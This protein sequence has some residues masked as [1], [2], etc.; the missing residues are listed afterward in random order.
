MQIKRLILLFLSFLFSISTLY[1][2]D[3]SEIV[4]AFEKKDVKKIETLLNSKVQF[5]QNQTDNIYSKTQATMVLDAFLKENN[6]QSAVLIHK[7]KKGISSF[8]IFNLITE[9]GNFRLYCLEKQVGDIFLIHQIRI[10]K[11]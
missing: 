1:S 3:I 11:Q 8:V 9:R 5:I 10:D 7:G 4:K 2:Q 6:P